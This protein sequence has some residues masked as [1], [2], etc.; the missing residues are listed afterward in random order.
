MD[1]EQK[2]EERMGHMQKMGWREKQEKQ[3][4][5]KFGFTVFIQENPT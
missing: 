1:K 2:M 5:E 4:K 3:R